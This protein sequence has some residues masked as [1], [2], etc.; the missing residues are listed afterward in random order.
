MLNELRKSISSVLYERTTSPFFGTLIV[1]W[2]IWNWKIP[3]LTLFISEDKLSTN[4]IDYI[5]E[6]CG[7]I[8]NLITYPL[9]STIVLLT[10][11]PFVTNGFYWLSLKFDIWRQNQ[12][13]FLEKKQLLTLEQSI[14]LRELISRQEERFEKMLQGKNLEIR[15]L[16]AQI[17]EFKNVP[18]QKVD[19]NDNVSE[20]SA[21]VEFRE[22][23]D[24]IK[25]DK[26]AVGKYNR[27]IT[28]I[29]NGHPLVSNGGDPNT[30]A[31]LESYGIIENTVSGRY[32]LTEKG[33]RFHRFMI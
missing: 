25:S 5:I 17:N 30:T 22:L 24:R 6:C 2:L 31:L 29:Q 4:R 14:E 26:A 13:S 15:Q 9:V 12:K 33:K 23:A 21:D 11:I 7:D 20:E 27:L 1:T 8:N 32:K 10:L 16:T 18:T 19:S 28:I 3:Y